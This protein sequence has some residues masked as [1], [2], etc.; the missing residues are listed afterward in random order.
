MSV[1]SAAR[2]ENGHALVEAVYG[3]LEAHYGMLEQSIIVQ[4]QVIALRDT[5]MLA[6]GSSYPVNAQQLM[7]D[8]HVRLAAHRSAILE[9]SALVEKG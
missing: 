7:A 1:E 3:L 9:V 8:Y 4:E 6:G 5:A 2:A